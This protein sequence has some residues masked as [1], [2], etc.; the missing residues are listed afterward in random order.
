MLLIYLVKKGQED[1]RQN[2]ATEKRW[3]ASFFIVIVVWFGILFSTV[4]Q[5]ANG[6]EVLVDNEVDLSYVTLPLMGLALTYTLS[7]IFV[8]VVYL[9]A[10]N[11]VKAR[12]Q[13]KYDLIERE[14]EIERQR[15]IRT[16]V[17]TRTAGEKEMVRKEADREP[18]INAFPS[19]PSSSN[20]EGKE[21]PNPV[22]IGRTCTSDS[23]G[24]I[25]TL[26]PTSSNNTNAELQNNDRKDQSKPRQYG[27]E[28]TH[29]DDLCSIVIP[30]RNE[31]E[32]IRKTIQNC[33]LQTYKNV[34]VIVVC[35]NCSDRTFSEATQVQD[36]RVRPFELTTK[37]AGKGIAL[38]YGVEK[39]AGKYILIL[40]GDGK[41]SSEFIEKAM[42]LFFTDKEIAGVQGRYVPSNRNYNF[43]TR[44]LSI[45][46][47]L[48]ST[49]YMTTR[50]I[51]N[52][53][54]YLGG[55]GFIIRKDVLNAVGRFNNH[56][57]DDYELSCRLFRSK[58]KIIFAPLSVDY[59]EK[60]PTLSIM[61]RQRARWAKGFLSLLKTREVKASDV[62]GSIY[63]LSPIASISGML[64]LA[65]FGYATLHNAMFDYYPYKYTYIP[66]NLW[67]S[68]V[69]T[70]FALQFGVLVKEY[71]RQGLKYAPFLALFNPF[72]LYTFVT[73]MKALFVKSWGDTKTAH[74][75]VTKG[76]SKDN[77]ERVLTSLD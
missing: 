64:V 25:S 49:P 13:Q 76:S 20:H 68:L 6:I 61:I 46:G 10:F 34:E 39:A 62:L 1:R 59:D 72:S 60:P 9:V 57:V 70:V 48:W 69:G 27:E 8:F 65:I 14:K 21:C 50:S 4:Y 67:F 36:A 52:K 35:H 15:Y 56:L 77:E 55:T 12:Q 2:M 16:V 40:D 24:A 44:L 33:L 17:T 45:E 28:N 37:E 11:K 38:N 75:F 54:V 3:I 42:P 22:N 71:G 26:A 29:Y 23:F 66:L 47:D 43:V 32:V 51:L 73:Y 31:E 63:W 5:W 41:L 7:G 30:S 19:S 74:G 53:Q 58:Y 18:L